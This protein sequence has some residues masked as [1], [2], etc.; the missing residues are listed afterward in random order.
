MQS[1]RPLVAAL[2]LVAL[3][4]LVRPAAAQLVIGPPDWSADRGRALDLINREDCLGEA[5][6]DFD[7]DFTDTVPG[8]F[9]LWAGAGCNDATKRA[10]DATGCVKVADGSN[11]GEKVTIRPRDLVKKAGDNDAATVEDCDADHGE[12]ILT[13]TLFFLVI[14]GNGEASVQ[15]QPAWEYSFDTVAPEPP[16]ITS[17]TSGESSLNLE[18]EAPTGE[19]LDDYRF[20]CAPADSDCEAAALPSGMP[21]DETTFCG[22]RDAT[23]TDSAA[24]DNKLQNNVLYAVAISSKDAAGN[25][26]N[27]SDL[28][29]A[30]PQEVTGF[31]EAYRAAGGQAGGGFCSY[32]PAHRGAAPMGAALLL[33]ILALWRRRR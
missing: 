28:A 17:A 31:F 9:E 32:A 5:T 22:D 21:P 4:L 11:P 24:T 33:G 10:G 12:G 20:Y 16:T 26:G 1:P 6:I 15:G 27:L 2:A 8:N 29:C 13:R 30:T 3:G 19:K 18:F 14:D 25:V 23:G 7:T